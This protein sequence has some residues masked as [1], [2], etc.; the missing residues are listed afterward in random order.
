MSILEQ[1]YD[2]INSL[3]FEQNTPLSL[4]I[5]QEKYFSSKALINNGAKVNLGGGFYGSCLN[6]TVI[7]QQLHLI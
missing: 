1:R 4:A 3:D 5:L 2:L 7:K 6:I